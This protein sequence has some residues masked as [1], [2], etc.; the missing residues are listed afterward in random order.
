MPK[1]KAA[2]KKKSSDKDALKQAVKEALLENPE[3]LQ[4]AITEALEDIGMGNAIREGLK[5][6]RATR[7]EIVRVLRRKSG[8][9]S[10]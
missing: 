5:S 10:I 4:D 9:S 3:I 7:E 2:P 6:G 8:R 1:T